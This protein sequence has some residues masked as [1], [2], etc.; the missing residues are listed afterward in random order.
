[1]G[2]AGSQRMEKFLGGCSTCFRFEDMRLPLGVLATDLVT[3]EAVEFSG[4]R[5]CGSAH[6]CQLL[7]PGAVSA[8]ACEETA[9]WWMAL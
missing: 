7:L 9:C 8:A 3:G 4:Y 2:F 6:P 5:R 1:M